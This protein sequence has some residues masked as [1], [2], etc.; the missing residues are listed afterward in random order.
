MHT[1]LQP[2]RIDPGLELCGQRPFARDADLQIRYG[3]ACQSRRFHQRVQSHTPC[4]PAR[5]EDHKPLCADAQSPAYR[6]TICRRK[7]LCIYT[8]GKSNDL[9]CRYAEPLPYISGHELT[10]GHDAMAASQRIA[11]DLKHSTMDQLQLQPFVSTFGRMFS[12]PWAMVNTQRWNG[13]GQCQPVVSPGCIGKMHDHGVGR[14]GGVQRQELPTEGTLPRYWVGA[15][16]AADLQTV[17]DLPF[18]QIRT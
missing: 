6:R 15:I 10:E 16:I 9:V 5:R 4:Q 11:L 8:A 1:V 14:F 18:R 17:P 3:L 2:E 7:P 13:A 12:I